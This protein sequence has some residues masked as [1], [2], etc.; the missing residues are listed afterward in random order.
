VSA[1]SVRERWLLGAVL[2]FAALMRAAYLIE[3]QQAPDFDRPQF[4]SQYHDY[5]A[6]AL[7]SGNWAPP[8]GVTDP[9]IPHQ[10]F[11]R[12]PGYPYFLALIYRVGG[13]GYLWPR[14]VQMLLG[15]ASCLLVYALTRRYFGSGAALVA[16]AMQGGYWIFIYFE[17]EFMAPSLLIFLVL[18]TLWSVSRWTVG[19]TVVG[20]MAAGAVAGLSALVRPNMLALIPVFVLWGVWVEWRRGDAADWLRFF[21]G[22][23]LFVVTSTL[24]VL[25]VTLRNHRVAD[26]WVL[27]TSNAGINLFIGLDPNGN[28]YT[29][30]VPELARLTGLDG[31]DSFDYPLITASVERRVGRKMK[32]SEVSRWF[33]RRALARAKDHP[34][35][36][37][38]S[39]GR[40]LLLFWGPA[41]I[42]NTKVI[43]Y[44]RLASPTL[45]RSLSFATCLALG[46]LGIGLCAFGFP[47]AA[48]ERIGSPGRP[49]ANVVVLLLLF[50]VTYAATYAPFFVASRFRVPVIPV[51]I[52][53]GGFAVQTLWRL[54]VNRRWRYL[55]VALLAFALL[56]VVTGAEWVPYQPDGSLWHWRR[57]LLYEEGGRPD[58]A[59]EE[60][61]AAVS[62]RPDN[63]EAQLSLAEA[64]ASAGDLE[65]AIRHYTLYLEL[66]PRS[67]IGSN[68]L[69]FALQ[70]SG[71]LQSAVLQWERTLEIDPSDPVALNN[72]A[73]SLLMHPDEA[74][75]D[76]PRAVALAERGVK[77]T[78]HQDD[79]LLRTL[80]AAYRAA[81]RRAEA[82]AV[83]DLLENPS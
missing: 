41:E 48:T 34:G 73:I 53:F 14:L 16:A 52:I 63:A 28:G 38:R 43:E 23:V 50:I 20:A 44:E 74:Q 40:K 64:C 24:V 68:N 15:L 70:R 26:D 30:G 79:D 9:D 57:G 27:I 75:R 51:L 46:L 31:W 21:R 18:L 71:D 1:V 69:A 13:T 6:R 54:V 39:L 22:A 76:I 56:R 12:P 55:A 82:Q 3:I 45:R 42:S 32:D 49:D 17:G 62:V 81:G 2:L 47:K 19:V 37:V 60:F 72:L 25:P 4:E 58:R 67:V 65:R 33:S 66:R 7:D 77:V 10:V 61:Q 59:L 29:P 83:E 78:A 5:W 11:F 36:V 80:A 8:D 35:A